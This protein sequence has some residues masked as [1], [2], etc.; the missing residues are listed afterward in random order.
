MGRLGEDDPRPVQL[1]TIY[2]L[3]S[4][5]KTIGLTTATYLLMAEG[6]LALDEPVQDIVPEFTG[7][8]KDGVTVRHLLTHT[9]GLPPWIPLHLETRD[10][11]DALHRVF[12]EPLDSM[13]GESF[14][15]SDLGAILMAE[16][17]ERRA[18]EPLD[19]FL[20]RRIFDP[21]DM[22]DTRFNPPPELLDRIAPTENDA[23]RGRM[24]RGEVHDENAFH[25]GGVSGHAGLFSSGADLTK[26]AQWMLASFAGTV[27]DSRPGIPGD[28]LRAWT[29]L[30]GNPE[31]GWRA[32]GWQ[33]PR[34]DGNNSAGTRMG[35]SAFGHTGFTG[36]SMWIDPGN[37]LFIILLT[38][39]V[40]PTRENTRWFPSRA[41]VADMVMRADKR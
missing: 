40:H 4:L 25:L 8:H 1:N 36:T 37:D 15:Y 12:T 26:F 3:A 2:D 24:I 27:S 35:A 16:V 17:V 29:G 23:W 10:R 6:R 19:A 31:H 39:R 14:V 32:I 38:N 13:P 30:Q 18:G 11:D 20:Q 22:V 33:K 41:A 28:S 7:D 34:P 5:T 21:L 9:S